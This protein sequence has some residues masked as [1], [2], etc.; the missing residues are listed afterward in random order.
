MLKTKV[1]A[2]INFAIAQEWVW[3]EILET[4]SII[5]LPSVF[6]DKR[7]KTKLKILFWGLGREVWRS[8]VVLKIK[9][10]VIRRNVTTECLLLKSDT[11][12][13][14]QKFWSENQMTLLQNKVQIPTWRSSRCLKFIIDIAIKGL[15][16]EKQ[17]TTF[18]W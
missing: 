14:L 17:I 5:P 2:A 12:G 8:I 1:S 11:I 13:I 7:Q 4:S 18:F 16:S 6:A 15:Y 9:Y 3:S 10:Y